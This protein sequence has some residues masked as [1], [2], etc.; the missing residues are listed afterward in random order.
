MIKELKNWEL[1]NL[2]VDIYMYNI[3]GRIIKEI[4]IIN[5]VNIRNF[6]INYK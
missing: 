5:Y 1:H 6:H 4:N 3:K 2:E